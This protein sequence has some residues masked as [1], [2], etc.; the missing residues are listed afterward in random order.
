VANKQIP[1]EGPG[2]WRRATKI[3]VAEK[4]A[5]EHPQAGLN[6]LNELAGLRGYSISKSVWVRARARARGRPHSSDPPARL[7]PLPPPPD[8]TEF[9][10]VLTQFAE[11]VKS[12]GGPEQV[13]SLLNLFHS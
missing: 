1:P 5:R 8:L 11:F 4:L 7:R 2:D 13:R 9:V 3:E 10:Q 12:L 6:R